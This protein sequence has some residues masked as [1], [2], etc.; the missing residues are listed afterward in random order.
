MWRFT[1]FLWIYNI[2]FMPFYYLLLGL[3]GIA[4]PR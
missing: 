1:M 2:V 3:L 4:T